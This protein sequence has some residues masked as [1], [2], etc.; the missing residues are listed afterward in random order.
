[1]KASLI[2]Y[3]TCIACSITSCTHPSS[4]R[5]TLKEVETYIEKHPDSAL[6]VLQDI[7][8]KHLNSKEEVALHALLLSMAMDKNFIDCTD[9]DI[10]QPAMDY[11]R[12]HGSATEKLRTLY[13][14]GRIHMNRGDNASAM[15]CFNKALNEG[16]SSDDILTKA[17]A[18]F[19]KANFYFAQYEWELSIE[20]YK[21]SADYFKQANS[22]NSYANCLIRSINA[23]ILKKD[24][25]KAGEIIRMFE[26][27]FD[28]VN[29]RRQIDFQNVRL[30]YVVENCNLKEIATFLS[31]YLAT[32]PD[33]GK[34]WISIATA[35]TCLDDYQTA[36]DYIQ[37]YEVTSS[38]QKDIRYYALLTRIYERV[39]MPDKALDAYKQYTHIT[40]SIDLATYRQSNIF[41]DEYHKNELQI[42]KERSKSET[43]IYIS[44]IILLILLGAYIWIRIR[45]SIS[46]EQKKRLENENERYRLQCLQIEEERDNLTRLLEHEH[47]LSETARKILSE[48]IN[49]LNNFF[50]THIKTPG[51]T[52]HSLNEEIEKI[53]I[54]KDTFLTTNRLSFTG[55]HPHFIRYLKEKGLNEWEINYC[56]LYALG[57][58]GKEIGA[59]IK[60]KSHYN[61]SSI[62]REKL[63]IG[64][65]DTNLGIYI[66]NL[67]NQT[68]FF[69]T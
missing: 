32:V 18:H 54:E 33:A 34:D 2:A 23:C 21:K 50:A 63:G 28:S 31:Q 15:I 46:A 55:S 27:L 8:P 3:I 52:A 66:R 43:T 12:N 9:F 61:Q 38:T 6:T 51:T 40:D 30:I 41:L 53:V 67:L 1:M 14:E 36:Y 57:L 47:E 5:E 35:Y 16:E 56:C 11:Y 26:P 22:T 48:R 25:A 60:M 65:H 58:N 24:M 4:Y 69:G 39:S 42:M 59:Y 49:L 19:T 37:K 68:S 62:I 64:E 7:T 10:L 13:Y 20:E 29:A 44:I 17:R 45:L